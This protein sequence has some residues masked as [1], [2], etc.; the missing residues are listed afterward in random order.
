MFCSHLNIE[1]STDLGI[2]LGFSLIDKRPCRSQVEHILRKKMKGKLANG[3]SKCL[4]KAGRW[5]LIKSS[6]NTIENYSMKTLLLPKASLVEL[7]QTCARFLLDS[8]AEKMK[9]HL[10]SWLK[11]C[12][13]ID[14][15]GLNV[16]ATTIMNYALLTKLCWKLD[17]SNNLDAQLI[18]E[19]Y[20]NNM[21][22][23]APFNLGSHIWQNVG[24]GWDL[25]SKCTGW[26]IGNG[27]NINLWLNDWTRKGSLRQLI[28]GPLQFNEENLT[29]NSL[30][31]S[32]QWVFNHLSLT[33]PPNITRWISAIHIPAKG[34][35][36]PF[37]TLGKGSFFDLKLAYRFL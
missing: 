17:T 34:Q 36:L 4:S 7:D 12:A 33:L 14:C 37:C 31:S 19:K 28:H 15:G 1:P 21:N 6:L 26:C 29:V 2:Y 24:K 27:L 30:M 23:P 5:T 10:L 32:D 16:R 3:K 13:P 11:V 8:T 18:K 20:V 25:Y 22:Y 35:D 9:T